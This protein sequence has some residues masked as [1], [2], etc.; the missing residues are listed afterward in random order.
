MRYEIKSLRVPGALKQLN[1]VQSVVASA[2]LNESTLLVKCLTVMCRHFDNIGTI[3][4]YEY[5]SS[6]IAI[7]VNV[8]QAVWSI[9][10]SC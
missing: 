10:T 9:Y 2:Q 6:V 5:I 1:S 8:V 4:N 7:A 3:A